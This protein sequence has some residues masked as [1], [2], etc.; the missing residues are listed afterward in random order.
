M[1][2]CE[3][4]S[5]EKMFLN[6]CEN[7][8]YDD[9]CNKYLLLIKNNKYS[10]NEL[11]NIINIGF[12]KCCE[13]DNI[14][15]AKFLYK[16]KR[17]TFF[18]IC[19][20]RYVDIVNNDAYKSALLYNH[21]DIVM[22]LQTLQG[23]KYNLSSKDL[24]DLFINCCHKDSIDS[25]K[26]LFVK[27]NYISEIINDKLFN[28]C[29]KKDSVNT[30]KWMYDISHI[31]DYVNKNSQMLFESSCCFGSIKTAKFLY[32]TNNC[33]IDKNNLINKNLLT[34]VITKNKYYIVIFLCNDCG[35]KLKNNMSS[36]TTIELCEKQY[37]TMLKHLCDFDE[38]DIYI[39]DLTLFITACINNKVELAKKVYKISN[40]TINCLKKNNIKY[41][42]LIMCV[43]HMCY[44]VIIWLCSLTE[45]NIDIRIENDILFKMICIMSN[46]NNKMSLKNFY[47]KN[48]IFFKKYFNNENIFHMTKLI[49]IIQSTD[50][51]NKLLLWF[52][53]E[54]QFSKSELEDYRKEYN[55][56]INF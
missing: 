15:Q 44:D 3:T 46:E 27:F 47:F 10:P 1:F 18:N 43:L 30:I 20:E 4:I 54:C 55:Y 49:G 24:I 45:L 29:L 12:V 32:T 13:C 40:K 53:A 52:L 14:N 35:M 42:L 51:I 41:T 16:L 50:N 23:N 48:I 22:W 21:V 33:S 5:I 31:T 28:E 6:S 34:D 37:L 7:E 19:G 26:Y 9:M 39:D 25:V 11:K 38:F 8:N 56:D 2:Y 36:L 17:Y